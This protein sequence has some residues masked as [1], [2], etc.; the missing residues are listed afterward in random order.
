MD[1]PINMHNENIALR[2]QKLLIRSA[3]LRINLA[4]QMLVFK[5]PLLMADQAKSSLQ[6][7]YRNPQWPLGALLILIIVRPHRIF[8]WSTRLWSAWKIFKQV[9]NM[10]PASF[11]SRNWQ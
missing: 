8:T 2:Q 3:H 9:R 7:L 5:K 10:M 4:Q 1:H 11:L 6:W